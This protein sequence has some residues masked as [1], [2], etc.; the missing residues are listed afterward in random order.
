MP[1][2]AGLV[3]LLTRSVAGTL[4]MPEE[5]DAAF[6]SAEYKLYEAMQGSKLTNST[7]TIH[8]WI[9]KFDGGN[10]RYMRMRFHDAASRAIVHSP[11]LCVGARLGGEVRGF[12][13]L[14][15]V[16]LAIGVDLEPG[17]KNEC[18]KPPCDSASPASM[19]WT[20]DGRMVR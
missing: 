14:P 1:Q 4:K 10:E 17:E 20:V 12:K 5:S 15:N 6:D 3:L 7:A 11:V 9:K 16:D 19:S 13:S 2:L 18:A 8:R